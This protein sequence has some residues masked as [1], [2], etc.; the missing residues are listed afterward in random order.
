M[1]SSNSWM[2]YSANNDYVRF[3]FENEND[4]FVY[5]NGA[6]IKGEWRILNSDNFIYLNYKNE[7]F[8]FKYSLVQKSLFVCYDEFH[9]EAILLYN[10]K[11]FNK[12]EIESVLSNWLSSSFSFFLRLLDDG[13]ILFVEGNQVW[14]DD[15]V[16]NNGNFRTVDGEVLDVVNGKIVGSIRYWSYSYYEDGLAI[17]H[18]IGSQP[19][20]GCE[21]F[22]NN[23]PAMDGVYRAMSS[24]YIRVNL[25]IISELSS[26]GIEFY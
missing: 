10:D 21:V 13:S 6:V 7:E 2:K 16:I 15:L 19:K 9:G 25:G 12:E 11:R 14:K 23:Y 24:M 20:V 26:N 1:I 8:I 18:D 17:K 3:F 22:I 4:L 5:E